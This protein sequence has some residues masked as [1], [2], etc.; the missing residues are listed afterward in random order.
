LKYSFS[1][2]LIFSFF[3]SF[4]Q[5]LKRKVLFLGNSYTGFNNLPAM[6]SAVAASVGDT[7]I[8]DSNNPG[9]YTFAGHLQDN[10]SLSKIQAGGWDF[11]VL[12]EQS[13]LPS[14][15]QYSIADAIGLKLKIR[16]FNPCARPL[17]YRTWGRK[18]GD[19]S[20]CSAWPPVCTYAGMDSLLH[21]RYMQMAQ[22]NHAEV[23]P[24]GSTWKYIRQQFPSIELYN[25]DE[26]HP[27]L[28]GTYAAACSFYASVF[29]KNPAA[30]PYNGGLTASEATNI[31]LAA[32]A[33]VFDSLANW[34]FPDLPPKAKFSYVTTTASNEIRFLNKS[35]RADSY[36]WD[37]G[38]GST[39]T[40]SDPVHT[41][42]G[43]GPFLV[44]LIVKRCDQDTT[45]VDGF[46][47]TIRFCAFTPTISPDTIMLCTVN[48]DTLWTQ[49]FENY[50]WFDANGDSIPGATQRFFIPTLSDNHYVR[51]SQN[52]CE[53]MSAPAFVD[54]ISSF[55]F[56]YVESVVQDSICVGD[57]VL[58]I[59]KP[60]TSP[61]PSDADIQWFRDG[62]PIP[63]S[64][65]DSVWI[66]GTG[67]YH[68]AVYDPQ[69][70]PG[71]PIFTTAALPV[72]F[73]NCQVSISEKMRNSP[74]VVYP[75]PGK[76][77]TIRI[78]PE[79][80]GSRYSVMDMVGRK[81]ESGILQGEMQVLKFESEPGGLYWLN[82][83]GVGIF[84]LMRE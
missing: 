82:V 12:Q 71:S 62:I 58:L 60:L 3:T 66:T 65:N 53:E 56:Y 50:Q 5:G 76:D 24:V 10:L 20:N 16:Q 1:L 2:I 11:V 41:Y 54:A 51:T 22:V 33:V 69:F 36:L 13:Q 52:G 26:S 55:N 63:F 49:N 32:K 25:A 23:S 44:S 84:R 6:V 29:K 37:F 21:L 77:F 83:E 48:P 68:A 57:T 19:A 4:G 39:S 59:L 15:P 79:K 61:L 45:Y 42:S 67:Q 81:V 72:E 17:F 35:Q 70:C 14:F 78:Q 43:N 47:K 74:V 30:I 8:Y 75:N 31:R 7:L 9:G 64:A 73:Q 34:Y 27:S 46:Q 38:D 28:A 40:L 80:I 18:N